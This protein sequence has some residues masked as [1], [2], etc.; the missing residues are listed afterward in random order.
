MDVIWNNVD[1]RNISIR[2]DNKIYIQY[3][4][5]ST[6]TLNFSVYP[7]GITNTDY[8]IEFKTTCD[9]DEQCKITDYFSVCNQT[10]HQCEK[11]ECIEDNVANSPFQ[12]TEISIPFTQLTGTLCNTFGD[13]Y[14]IHLNK[15]EVVIFELPNNIYSTSLSYTIYNKIATENNTVNSK[16]YEFKVPE[17]DDYY[18]HIKS[19]SEITG[20]TLNVNYKSELCNELNCSETKNEICE[21]NYYSG[22]TECVCNKGSMKDENGNCVNVCENIDC[23]G[24]AN[25]SCSIT[26]YGTAS[27]CMCDEGYTYHVWARYPLTEED[28]CV[29]IDEVINYVDCSDKPNTHPEGSCGMYWVG[30]GFQCVCDEG[31]LSSNGKCVTKEKFCDDCNSKENTFC[32]G[33]KGTCECAEGFMED[34]DKNCIPLSEG[35]N[36]VVC[37][38]ENTHCEIIYNSNYSYY[39]P[40]YEPK[41]LCNEGYG[42]NGRY[43]VNIDLC[44]DDET[45]NTIETATQI[46]I[47]YSGE[48]FFCPGKNDYFKADLTAG[49]GIIFDIYPNNNHLGYYLKIG[50]LSGETIEF[51][52]PEY[53]YDF[54]YFIPEETGIYYFEISSDSYP[55]EGYYSLMIE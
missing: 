35:C 26:I 8:T 16:G 50:K 42:N 19:D 51:S 31:Y 14:K 37:S 28:G 25:T 20:Y 48:N 49:K 41:C 40:K 46:T 53:T 21:L 45:G 27:Y 13:W 11:T 3:L 12:A 2:K 1:L 17:T 9:L 47:P 55:N 6:K 15:D 52:N 24:K 18:I 34:K 36:G 44:S 33:E 39:N 32:D 10:T 38:E 29:P 23:L 7:K 43:C 5:D 54:S 30:C 4:S 22:K